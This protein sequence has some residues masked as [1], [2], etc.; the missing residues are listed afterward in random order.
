[1]MLLLHHQCKGSVPWTFSKKLLK[2]FLVEVTVL[3][4]CSLVG[5]FHLLSRGEHM[6]LVSPTLSCSPL[7][8]S[9]HSVTV[10]FTLQNQTLRGKHPLCF[11][12]LIIHKFNFL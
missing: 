11:W 9:G 5:N 2:T 8:P 6:M 4:I 1:M 12:N 7:P 3:I 10:G